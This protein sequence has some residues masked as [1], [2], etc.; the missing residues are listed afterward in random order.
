MICLFLHFLFFKMNIYCLCNNK[1]VNFDSI[2]KSK[3]CWGQNVAVLCATL[4][5]NERDKEEKG[6]EEN[7]IQWTKGLEEIDQRGECGAI[8]EENYMRKEVIWRRIPKCH[9]GGG[10]RYWK[11]DVGPAVPGQPDVS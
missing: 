6:M 2:A 11:A 7:E 10:E 4:G 3:C 8:C 9:G 5:L 1:N